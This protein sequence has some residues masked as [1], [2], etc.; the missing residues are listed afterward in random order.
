[1][2]KLLTRKEQIIGI[3]AMLVMKSTRIPTRSI[4]NPGI[5][6]YTPMPTVLAAYERIAYFN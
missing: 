1:M 6:R 4:G 3:V 2:C 5:H